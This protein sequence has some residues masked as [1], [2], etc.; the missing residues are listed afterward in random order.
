MPGVAFGTG[1]V[2]LMNK[3]QKK[4]KQHLFEKRSISHHATALQCVYD[5]LIF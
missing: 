5:V 3:G 4:S 1:S 2:L